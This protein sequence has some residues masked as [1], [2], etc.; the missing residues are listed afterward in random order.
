MA[1]NLGL[2]IYLEPTGLGYPFPDAIGFK[3][4][5][6]TQIIHTT[7]VTGD[8]VDM[9]IPLVRMPGEARNDF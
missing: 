9:E 4:L 8:S 2:P 7:A 6:H 3:K 1:E 5:T